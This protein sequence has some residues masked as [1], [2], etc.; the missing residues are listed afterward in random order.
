MKF[1]L[2]WSGKLEYPCREYRKDEHFRVHST[3]AGTVEA[4]G[5]PG[6]LFVNGRRCL[7]APYRS[8]A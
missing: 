7:Q 5:N 6:L 4:R 3:A 8:P 1:S 2:N